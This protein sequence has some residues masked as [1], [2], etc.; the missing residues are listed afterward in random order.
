MP[1]QRSRLRHNWNPL[2]LGEL[3]QAE[4]AWRLGEAPV[5]ARCG[6]T[7]RAVLRRVGRQVVCYACSVDPQGRRETEID[8]PLGR[9]RNAH[10]VATVPANDNQLFN[11]PDD[12]PEARLRWLLQPSDRVRR[13]LRQR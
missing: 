6:E 11:D 7:R 12:G 4:R 10:H 5:C 3:R 1:R 8:H 9:R 2:L 13:M